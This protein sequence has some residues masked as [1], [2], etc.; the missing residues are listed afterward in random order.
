MPHREAP[1]AQI[2]LDR[3]GESQQSQRV[4]NRRAI[5]PDA[6][7]QF[8]LGPAELGEELLIRFRLFHRVQILAEKVLHERNLEALSVGCLA[9]DGRNAREPSLARR[10]PT[11][12][13][14]DELI[15]VAIATNDDRL[16]DSR[17]AD[18]GR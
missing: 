14:R 8:L 10:A 1:A 2:G 16:N 13:A 15:A 7:S 17:R 5:E 12:L 3:L 18:R 9:H 6:L 4:R 11:T